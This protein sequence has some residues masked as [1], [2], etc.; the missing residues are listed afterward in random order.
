MGQIV[1]IIPFHDHEIATIRDGD[2]V[3][4]A[5]K[6]IVAE[7]GLAWNGQ[8]EK[9][10]RHPVLSEGIRVTRIPSAGGMQETTLLALNMLPGYLATIQPDRIKNPDIKEK[11]VLFQREAFDV[12]FQHFFGASPARQTA[13]PGTNDLFRI[14]DRI[15]RERQ[16]AVRDM[17]HHQ[18][19]NMCERLNIPVAPLDCIGQAAPSIAAVCAPFFAGLMT[20]DTKKVQWDWHRRADLAAFNMPQLIELFEQH[21][22]NCL[23]GADL[24]ISLRQHPAFVDVRNVNGTDGKVRVCWIFRRDRMTENHYG[25]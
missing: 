24:R 13:P 9:I 20:L 11:V 23:I 12:L 21:E 14:V 5:L 25:G 22:I 7:L 1:E 6:H 2:T 15:E 3:L 4:V 8:Y 18:L 17:L 16:P 10:R 19:T